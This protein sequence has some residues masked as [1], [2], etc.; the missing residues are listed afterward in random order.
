VDYDQILPNLYVGS[1]PRWPEDIDTLKAAGITAVLNVQSDDDCH[2]LNID[3]SSLQTHYFAV[4][5]E[6]RR[7]RI[8]DFDDADLRG[9]LPGAVD[10]LSDLLGKGHTVF[11]HCSA[12]INRSPSVVICYL[13]WCEARDLDDAERHVRRCRSCNPVMDVIRLAT[14]DRQA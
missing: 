6:A 12:G 13:H 3:W 2:Y 11:V 10:E 14:R 9:K 1:H 5:L 7:F 4:G 8:Q